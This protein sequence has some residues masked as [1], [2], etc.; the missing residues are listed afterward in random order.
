VGSTVWRQNP[1]CSAWGADITPISKL[2]S[3]DGPASSILSKCLRQN[4][5]DSVLAMDFSICSWDVRE[6][7]VTPT[8]SHLCQ[9]SLPFAAFPPSPPPSS[10]LCL[11]DLQGLLWRIF[12][13]KRAPTGW[14]DVQRSGLFKVGT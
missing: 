13:T 7:A 6:Q 3:W 14:V 5:G 10:L 9:S 11:V 1:S 2:L 12:L 8:C 4:S